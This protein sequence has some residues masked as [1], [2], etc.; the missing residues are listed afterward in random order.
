MLTE[1]L[2]MSKP[3]LCGRTHLQF[4]QANVEVQNCERVCGLPNSTDTETL[5]AQTKTEKEGRTHNSIYP[6][7]EVSCSADTFVK[8][9][10]LVLI[11]TIYTG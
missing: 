9:E 4:T 8:A 2:T 3:T 10:S 7:G 11:L 6:K 5:G 1:T